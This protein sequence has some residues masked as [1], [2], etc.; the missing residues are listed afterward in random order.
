VVSSER[1]IL[2]VRRESP[3]TEQR[4][5]GVDHDRELPERWRCLVL[6]FSDPKVGM[7]NSFP[8]SAPIPAI[9]SR[10]SCASESVGS[11][12]S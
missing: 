4:Q 11:P 8:F 12:L 1:L 3:D 6:T 2:P 5:A 9:R 10:R 7:E